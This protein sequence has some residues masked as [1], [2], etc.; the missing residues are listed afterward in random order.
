MSAEGFMCVIEPD[1]PLLFR[2]PDALLS[3]EENLCGLF[4]PTELEQNEPML[5]AGRL[6]GTRL[7]YPAGMR[8]VLL[9]DGYAGLLGR[10]GR[11]FDGIFRS[12]DRALIR[13][14]IFAKEERGFTGVF[15]G[16][17]SRDIVE[18]YDAAIYATYIASRDFQAKSDQP[19]DERTLEKTP[20][21]EVKDWRYIARNRYVIAGMPLSISYAAP[22][23]ISRSFAHFAALQLLSDYTLDNGIPYPSRKQSPMGFIVSRRTRIVPNADYKMAN[24]AAFAGLSI[25]PGVDPVFVN[26]LREKVNERREGSRAPYR[27]ES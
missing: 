15:P 26:F 19:I 5:L 9:I 17:I 3:N 11:D 21:I 24:A 20:P 25:L 16:S 10:Y 7:A 22:K 27:G 12:D 23:N 18:R 4:V 8:C 14:F 13:E 1:H 6:I 2:G